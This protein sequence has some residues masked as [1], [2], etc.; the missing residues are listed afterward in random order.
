[1]AKRFIN[2]PDIWRGI[3]CSFNRVGD[4]Y[5]DQLSYGGHYER[6]ESDIECF[7]STGISAIRYPV[8]W[9][10]HQPSLTT[11]IDW[12]WTT[13]QLNA[14][15]SHGIH[16]IAGLMHHGNGP[17]FTDLL[18]DSFPALFSAYAAKV[19]EQFPWIEYYNPVNEPLTTA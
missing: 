2:I 9:E 1:M 15:R 18:S 14:L 3:E 5:M 19:A 4:R 12:T 17:P 13:R 11:A 6:G 10:K 7:A 16:P 8:I